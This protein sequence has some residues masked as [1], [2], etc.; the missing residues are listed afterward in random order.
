L[1]VPVGIGMLFANKRNL[2][3]LDELPRFEAQVVD[4]ALVAD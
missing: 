2:Q 1:S 4:G 3:T